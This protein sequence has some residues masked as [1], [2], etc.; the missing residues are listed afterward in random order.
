MKTSIVVA[1]IAFVL[2]VTI[3]YF[4]VNYKYAKVYD[5]EHFGFVIGTH[6]EQ[7]IYSLCER[8]LVKGFSL[9]LSTSISI[10]FLNCNDTNTLKLI[11]DADKW[12]FM[13]KKNG[14][15]TISFLF[16]SDTLIRIITLHDN[17][18]LPKDW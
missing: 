12:S 5:G 6:K 9:T 10:L 3:L 1:A 11:R 7:V 17:T 18:F 15:E 14:V 13:K 4:K 8:G 16:D 2:I